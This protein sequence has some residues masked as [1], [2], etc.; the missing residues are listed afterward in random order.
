MFIYGLVVFRTFFNLSLNKV[1]KTTRLYT[2]KYIL[3]VYF[4]LYVDHFLKVFID[5]SP[6]SQSYGFSSMDI[7]VG[8]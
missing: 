5:F 2:H 6:S 8:M 7:R 3:R 4:Y 1:G